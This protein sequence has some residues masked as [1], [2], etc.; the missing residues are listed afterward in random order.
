M[1]HD[2]SQHDGDEHSQTGERPHE[3]VVPPTID[4]TYPVIANSRQGR[5]QKP[6]QEQQDEDDQKLKDDGDRDKKHGNS[7]DRQRDENGGG[8]NRGGQQARQHDRDRRGDQE[9]R[10]EDRSPQQ[11]P[12]MMKNLLT[13]AGVALVCGVIG[14]TGYAH[15]F[16]PKP[17]GS[18]S[19]QSQGE[20]D[21]GSKN[22][23]GSEE[24]SS[25]AE[26][27]ASGKESTAQASA[28]NSVPGVSSTKDADMIKQQI[29]D[30]SRRVQQ[31]ARAGGWCD[32]AH[33]RDAAGAANDA[34]QDEQV[35]SRDGRSLRP[36]RGVPA[37]RQTT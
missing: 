1:G 36:A 32:P 34:G 25:G 30:L 27:K 33:G 17:E 12:S 26:N 18:R 37:L 2:K 3:A 35:G 23:S 16:G 19:D 4:A 24:K 28:T 20:S 6:D 31:F 11:Q 21:S 22:D 9:D 15:F 7:Q 13:T 5:G 14:A 8:K 10:G 29:K